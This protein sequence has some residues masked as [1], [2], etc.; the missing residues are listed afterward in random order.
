MIEFDADKERT[1]LAKHRISLAR[2]ADL[3]ILATLQDDR[4]DYG[5]TRYRAWGL[6]DGDAYC[7]AFTV[8]EGRVRAI[9]LRRAHAKEMKR[10]VAKDTAD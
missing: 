3:E 9:S 7:L 4:F 1:N 8:R 2:A 10:Y 5:E 6:I